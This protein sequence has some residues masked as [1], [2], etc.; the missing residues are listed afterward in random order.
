MLE[1]RMVLLTNWA[2][3]SEAVLIN[4]D[5]R[6]KWITLIQSAALRRIKN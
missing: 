1:G 2:G 4:V 3:P 6:N 5:G